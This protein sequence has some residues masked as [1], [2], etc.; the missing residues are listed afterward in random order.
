MAVVV[1]AVEEVAG[2]EGDPHQWITMPITSV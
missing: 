1:V 2:V